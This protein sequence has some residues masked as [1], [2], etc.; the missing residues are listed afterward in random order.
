MENAKLDK[1]IELLSRLKTIRGYKD[2]AEQVLEEIQN[3]EDV[4]LNVETWSNGIHY[5]LPITTTKE[6]CTYLIQH[7]IS[8]WDKKLDEIEK[9]IEETVHPM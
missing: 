5:S 1:Y 4:K 9:Q 7:I 6:N 3:K 2:E 8:G